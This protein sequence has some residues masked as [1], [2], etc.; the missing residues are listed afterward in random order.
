M[1]FRETSRTFSQIHA[2][3]SCD[4]LRLSLQ[5]SRRFP[6]FLIVYLFYFWFPFSL[7]FCFDYVWQIE[8]AGK[9]VSVH[10][11]CNIAMYN[12]VSEENKKRIYL[13]SKPLGSVYCLQR[14]AILILTLKQRIFISRYK[15]NNDVTSNRH[16][17]K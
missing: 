6:D 17:Q 14:Q 8:L 12:I 13:M 2:T 3:V 15:Q 4:S 16:V 1:R 9:S 11:L 10:T 5:T 7:I